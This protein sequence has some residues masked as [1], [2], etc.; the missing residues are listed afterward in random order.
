M[1]SRD[2]WHPDLARH[3]RVIP[4][5]IRQKPGNRHIIKGF[6]GSGV[7]ASC[8]WASRM[9]EKRCETC[10]RAWPGFGVNAPGLMPQDQCP[11][12]RQQ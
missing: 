12:R 4:Y 1:K 8:L 11:A 7:R 3:C 9:G 2:I 10:F 5:P 6:P